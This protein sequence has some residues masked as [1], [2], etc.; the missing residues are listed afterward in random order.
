V[1][2]RPA[3]EHGFRRR[4]VVVANPRQLIRDWQ[5]RFRD[6]SLTVLLA[7]N[8]IGMFFAVPLAAKGLPLARIV[9]D[10]LI[11][12][13][14]AIVVLL[15][16][17]RAASVAILLGLGAFAASQIFGAGWPP[18]ARSAVRRS[19]EVVAWSALIPVV[20]HAVYAPGRIT[21]R[22][23]QGAAVVYLGAAS[24]FASAY[25]LVWAFTPGAFTNLHGSPGDDQGTAELLYF[26]LTTLTTTGY[27]DILPV[28]PFARSLAN[29]ESVIGPF[30]LA[31]TIA[32][33]VTLELADRR[34]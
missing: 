15:S 8:L 32:R 28:D 31:I 6:P 22:R 4:S 30:Y 11:L 17:K 33:L 18:I 5:D 12:A 29:L 13:A 27:G 19:G 1:P 14:V 21:S 16:H 20:I 9:A 2:K 24:L 7:L 26:S 10:T 25:A 3:A 23:L 34:R